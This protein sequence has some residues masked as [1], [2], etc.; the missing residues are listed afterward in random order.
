[1]GGVLVG[2]R[3]GVRTGAFAGA[4]RVAD[5][6]T[7]VRLGLLMIPQPYP[8]RG[9]NEPGQPGFPTKRAFRP[10][11]STNLLSGQ[12]IIVSMA[13]SEQASRDAL[14]RIL[15]LVVLINDDMTRSLARDGLTVSRAA[16]VWELHRRGP[17]TQRELAQ[18]LHVSARTITGLVDGLSTTGFVTREPHPSD[19]RATLVTLTK[20]GTRT[21]RAL[22]R[23]QQDFAELL[24]GRM[25]AERFGCFVAG[26]DEVLS[27]LREAGL[28]VTHREET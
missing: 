28:T 3:A 26:L 23:G 21:T 15:Q 8:E 22:H 1:L 6:F 13:H 2:V 9:T 4:V 19:R 20:R 18:A 5:A 12:C 7:G 24:F 14:D 11:T 16:V 27:R 17:T 25:P 10:N